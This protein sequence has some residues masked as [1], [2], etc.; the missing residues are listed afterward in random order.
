M[1]GSVE[2]I[3]LRGIPK[4][5]LGDNIPKCI[6]DAL[7]STN[8]S[9]VDGDIIVIAH[10]IVSKAE[11]RVIESSQINVTP[12]AQDIA[13]RSDFDAVQVEIALGEGRA[14][15]RDERALIIELPNGHICNFGGVDH[16]NAPPSSYLLLPRD[17]DR[18][19]KLLRTEIE[20]QSRKKIAVIISDTEG[21]PWRKGAINIAIGCAGINAFKHNQGKQDLYGRILQRSMICQVDQIASAA[22]LVMGQADEGIPV[23]I[24]RGYDYE[25][26]N[27]K[28]SDIHRT[29]E[30]NLFR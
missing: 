1:V 9:L 25:R 23:V 30:E 11:G 8:I 7:D 3:P 15:I 12:R 6:L 26:G 20:E 14:V 29:G 27:E 19:A 17:P 21:R 28:V 16:S 24:I 4:I 2:I 10:T 18:S 22:E 5:D 13:N